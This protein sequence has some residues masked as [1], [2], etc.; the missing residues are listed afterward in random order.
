MFGAR[1]N[2]GRG[3]LAG[4]EGEDDFGWKER[5]HQNKQAQKERQ[6]PLL[7]L[8]GR[9]ACFN[10]NNLPRWKLFLSWTSSSFERLAM[11]SRWWSGKFDPQW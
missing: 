9:L 6:F 11:L 7:I 1:V 8:A 10:A 3:R 2:P 4:P 5:R